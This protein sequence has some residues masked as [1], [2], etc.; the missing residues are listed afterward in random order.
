[1]QCGMRERGGFVVW[2]MMDACARCGAGWVGS[3]ACVHMLGMRGGIWK[4]NID[5]ALS[6]NNP[7]F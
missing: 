6:E 2:Q 4:V 7:L 1:M 3:G 5:A